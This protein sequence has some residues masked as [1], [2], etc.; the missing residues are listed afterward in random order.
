MGFLDSVSKFTNGVKEKTKG[1]VDVFSLGQQ[2]ANTQKEINDLFL[3]L[4]TRYYELHKD[5]AEADLSGFV[6]SITSN[7]DKI[8]ELKEEIEKK[9]AEI[10]AIEL[11]DKSEQQ[12]NVK[13]T[14]KGRVCPNCKNPVADDELFCGSCG[15][16]IPKDEPAEDNTET[17]QS[18]PASDIEQSRRFCKECGTELT[19]DARFCPTCGTKN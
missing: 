7:Y 12:E 6:T 19:E 13:I 4:G 17:E 16:A 14:G 18:E 1:N 15:T 5:D 2:V 8:A 11:T 3:Q 10:A 9:K